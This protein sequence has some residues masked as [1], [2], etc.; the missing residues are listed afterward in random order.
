MTFDL[1][2]VGWPN[3][4]AIL[5]LAIMPVMALTT[6]PDRRLAAILVEP[7]AICQTSPACSTVIAAAPET[8]VK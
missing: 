8:I 5:T 7:A 3:T 4:A 1:V 2:R 6:P